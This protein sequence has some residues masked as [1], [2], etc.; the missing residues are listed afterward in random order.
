MKREI[1]MILWFPIILLTLTLSGYA[2]EKFQSHWKNSEIS[3]D[4][5]A[6]D[7][8][9]YPTQ[10][11]ADSDIPMLLGVVNDDTS[12][13]IMLKFRDLQVARMM[14]HRGFVLWLNGQDKKKKNFGILYKNTNMVPPGPPPSRVNDY[15]DSSAHNFKPDFPPAGN[16]S[17]ITQDTT[18]ISGNELGGLQ[19]RVKMENGVYCYEMNIP[20]QKNGDSFYKINAIPPQKLKLGIEVLSFNKKIK[21]GFKERPRERGDRPPDMGGDERGPGGP[22]PGMGRGRPGEGPRGG[23]PDHGGKEWWITVILARP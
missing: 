23:M 17:L 3:V 10:Y 11:Y 16:F 12:L 13:N 4:G 22:P 19:A 20:L 5:D 7:W 1:L 21:G 15:P 14:E 9:D 8:I 18:E 2:G 6:N